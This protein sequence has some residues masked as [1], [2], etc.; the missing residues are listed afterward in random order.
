MKILVYFLIISSYLTAN[1]QVYKSSNLHKGSAKSSFFMVS[2]QDEKDLSKDLEDY[3]IGFGKVSALEKHT[4]R[5][6]KL[7]DLNIGNDLTYIDIAVLG[8]KKMGKIV[9]FFLDKDEKALSAVKM[10]EKEAIVFI[11]NFQKFTLKNLEEDLLKEN[12][13]LAQ[14]HFEDAKKY[15]SKIEKSLEGNLKEQEKLGKKL[16]SSPEKLTKALS[17]KEEIVSELFSET[18][19]EKTRIELEKASAK[20]EKEIARIQKEKEKTETKLGKKEREFDALKDDLF[21]AKN[22]LKASS[23]VFEDAK[24]TLENF[25]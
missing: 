18:E 21:D 16:D 15:L 25:K 8:T 11:E 5:L 23:L 9:F 22:K 2:N 3:L 19:K 6:E 20:K 10:K 13:K 4:K 24:K 7:K 14:D 1:A 17:E 12:L